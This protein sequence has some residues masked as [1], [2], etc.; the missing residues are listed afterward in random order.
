MAALSCDGHVYTMG[1][2]AHGQLGHGDRKSK[3]TL[4]MVESL[5]DRHI[6]DVKCGKYMTVALSANGDLYT[7]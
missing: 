3:K 4:T 2:G 7:W 6:V 1:R 5:H